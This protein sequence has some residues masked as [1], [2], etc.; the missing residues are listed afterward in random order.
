[1][2]ICEPRCS[3]GNRMINHWQHVEMKPGYNDNWWGSFYVPEKTVY[4]FTVQAWIDHFDTWYDGFKKKAHANVDV[5]VEITGRDSVAEAPFQ[6]RKMID[7]PRQSS[8]WKENIL[9]R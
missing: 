3:T 8:R 9:R 2:I 7:L 4:V 6:R 5:H 1:M